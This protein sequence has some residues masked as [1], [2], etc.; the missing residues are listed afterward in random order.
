M[1]KHKRTKSVLLV[2][3]IVGVTQVLVAVGSCCSRFK[4][5]SFFLKEFIA[6]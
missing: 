1:V 6:I 3:C 2:S 4:S 5:R